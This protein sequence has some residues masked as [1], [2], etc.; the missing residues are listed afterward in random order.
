MW[1][2]L[3]EHGLQDWV[4]LLGGKG[5]SVAPPCGVTWGGAYR[6]DPSINLKA[7]EASSVIFLAC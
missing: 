6:G 5:L 2:L 7:E 4:Q 3:S 1:Y